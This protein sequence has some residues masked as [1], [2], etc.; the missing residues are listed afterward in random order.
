MKTII[1]VDGYNLFYGCLKHS[2]DKWLDLNALL[3]DR[4]LR[5][6]APGSKLLAIKFFTADIKAKVASRGDKAQQ[7]QQSYHRA[8][9]ALYPDT[10]QIIKGYYSLEKA[11]LPVHQTPPDKDRRVAVWR[12]EEKQT[13]VNIAVAAYRDALKTDA[14]Q[15]VFVSNDTD[16]APVLAALREDLGHMIRLGV[17]IP[18]RSG[19]G[20]AGN[21][22]LS[23]YSDW[24]RRHF[25]DQELR[26]SQ[27]PDRI[28]TGRKPIR[29]PSYW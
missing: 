4:V 24:T 19:K 17:V 29:K 9:R 20:R 15:L 5:A 6:Q 8:L 25:T 21:A 3:V 12:L 11:H 27:L 18:V 7:A 16:L 10:I 28:A 14:R 2:R 1:Y 23:R 13:D 22:Q 26:E